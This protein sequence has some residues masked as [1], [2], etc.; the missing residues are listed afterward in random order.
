MERSWWW[1]AALYGAVVVLSCLY[2][3][4]SVVPQEKQPAIIQ[5]LFH[6]RI[7]KGLDLAGG[8]RLVYNV[9]I[10]KAVSTKV[11]QIANAVED[12]LHKQVKDVHV[13]REGRDE[14][15]FTFKNPADAAKLTD[16]VLAEYR[17]DVD[18]LSKD[19]GKGVVRY[20]LDPDQVAEIQDFSLRQGIETIRGRVDKF[21]VAEPTIIK[22][23][24]DIVIELPGLE[25]RDFERIKSIIGRTAQLQFKIV[26]SASEYAKKVAATVQP[27]SGITVEPDSWRSQKTGALHEVVFLRAKDRATLEKFVAGLTGELAVPNDREFG[28]EEVVS[29]GEGNA[30]TERFWR[31]YLLHRRAG[32][33]GDYLADADVGFTEMGTPNVLFTMNRK[34]GDLMGKL[35]GENVGRRM[36]IV[37]DEKISSAP[38]IQSQI[39]ERGEINLGAA[40][41]PVALQQ[42]AKDLVAVL[43]SGSLPAPLT[44]TFET[45]VGKTLGDDT[46]QRAMLSMYVGAAAVVLFMLFYYKLAGVISI[47][48]MLLNLLFMVAIL[49]AFEAALT[50]PG[51]AGLVLTIGMA[52]DANIIIYE[53]IREELRLGKSPR[54]AVDAGFDRAFWTVFDGHVTTFVAG[55]VLYSYGSGPIRGFAVTLLVGIISNLLTSVWISRWMFDALVGRRSGPAHLSI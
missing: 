42:E 53:R 1:K 47:M 33:T 25:Q 55:V 34:G 6:K 29:K 13:A 39:N 37:L 8:L 5:K 16:D 17:D 38:E 27:T 48:A 49:A 51:I 30:G 9:D 40:I 12:S 15:V 18:V 31:S 43:R 20:R 32:V 22:K 45:Q 3:V 4:P 7:Q 50:L 21:G 14:I 35:T 46:V 52:V 11:D 23:G 26:D 41:D 19:E 28:Y 10:D 36:A 2:L 24:N 54:S 44:K